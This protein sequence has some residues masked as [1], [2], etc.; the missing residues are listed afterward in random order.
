MGTGIV[1]GGGGILGGFQVGALKFLYEH[2]C[3][4]D[5]SC[6][7][8]TSVGAING[9]IIATGDCWP[10]R[11]EHFW[12][13][14]VLTTGD[15]LRQQEWFD[16]VY[17]LWN[18]TVSDAPYSYMHAIRNFISNSARASR[19][20]ILEG[21]LKELGDIR[22]LIRSVATRNSLYATDILKGRLETLDL[23]QVINSKIALRFYATDLETGEVTCFANTAGL[24]NEPGTEKSGPHIKLES[25]DELVEA[26]LAS[27]ALP[28]AF[29]PVSVN[30]RYYVDGSLREIL[31]IKGT[32]I[33]RSDD[34]NTEKTYAILCSPCLSEAQ[35]FQDPY[36]LAHTCTGAIDVHD[37]DWG[38]SHLLGVAKRSAEIVLDEIVQAN[39]EE[40]KSEKHGPVL[41]IDPLVAV[42]ELMDLHIGLI[43]INIDQGYMRAF[44][45]I[46]A[47]KNAGDCTQLTRLIT[48][49]RVLIWKAE[50]ALIE[51]WSRAKHRSPLRDL[52]PSPLFYPIDVAKYWLDRDVVDTS[53]LRRIRRMKRNLKACIMKR[54]E[55]AGDESLPLHYEDM[56]RKWES[57]NWD[58]E[59]PTAEPLI[60]TPWDRFDLRRQG[61]EVIPAERPP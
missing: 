40:I 56:W 31:P 34:S 30:G 47:H 38:R 19:D 13:D 15:L 18:K 53:I 22:E 59:M 32:D 61:S 26:V 42:H 2:H 35:K 28:G 6:V 7:C 11:L 21:G 51:D 55:I 20:Y 41:I 49:E 9:A 27:A 3:V 57:H 60:A 12:L 36:G 17:T 1:L 52:L 37:T 14:N 44:D 16:A 24:A 4:D 5:I 10:E 23:S 58:I 46:G 48:S 33:C 45:K 29:P 39:I 50:H 25:H 43:K 54:R 8:G